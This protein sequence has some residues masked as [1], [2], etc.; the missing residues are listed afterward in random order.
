MSGRPCV[1]LKPFPQVRIIPSREGFNE[2][3][4]EGASSCYFDL[5]GSRR[6]AQVPDLNILASRGLIAHW[7]LEHDRCLLPELAQ[8]KLPNVCPIVFDALLLGS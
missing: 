4:G 6:T 1:G 8:R 5:T 3:M 2:L 7:H